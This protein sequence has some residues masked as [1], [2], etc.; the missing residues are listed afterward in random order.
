MSLLERLAGTWRATETLH[1]SPWNPAPGPAEAMLVARLALG[2]K[3]LVQDYRRKDYRGLGVL[4][5][6]AQQYDLWWFD[7]IEPP[8][9]AK[10]RG[11]GDRLVLEREGPTGRARYTYVFVGDG[12]FTFRIE[13]SRDGKEWQSFLDA[14]YVRVAAPEAP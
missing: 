5:R 7:A 10:G 3:A 2:G 13:R 8:G 9:P 12:E 4:L 14:R 1:P 11:L 6:D